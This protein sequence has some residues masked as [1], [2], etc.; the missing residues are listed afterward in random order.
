[1]KE[2]IENAKI[3]PLDDETPGFYLGGWYCPRCD[4]FHPQNMSCGP[5]HLIWDKKKKDY[6]GI[7]QRLL[8]FQ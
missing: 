5:E 4:A 8:Y 2:N 6:I 3:M 1:M 7:G